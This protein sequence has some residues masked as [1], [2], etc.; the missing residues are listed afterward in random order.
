MRSRVSLFI[1]LLLIATIIRSQTQLT[2]FTELYHN[3]RIMANDKLKTRNILAFL[4]I[5][6]LTLHNVSSPQT[7]SEKAYAH[8]NRGCGRP[9]L[10]SVAWSLSSS[11]T[12]SPSM[13]AS[14]V[15]KPMTRSSSFVKVDSARLF[16]ARYARAFDE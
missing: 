7:L 5:L 16:L 13:P 2:P 4:M 12:W 6:G 15:M 9:L 10:K 11:M 1:D 3:R 8:A 14:S